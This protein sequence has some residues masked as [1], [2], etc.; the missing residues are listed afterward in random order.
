MTIRRKAL[1]SITIAVVLLTA[2]TTLVSAQA[3]ARAYS[4]GAVLPPL[5]EW[6]IIGPVLRFLG[7]VQDA[8]P[9]VGP[10]PDP[11]LPEYRI[12]S[13]EDVEQLHDIE[14][15]RRVRIIATDTDLN[16]MIRDLLSEAGHSEAA[17]LRVAFDDPMIAADA[18]VSTT[19]IDRAGVDVPA[20]VRGNFNIL[21]TFTAVASNCS[22]TVTF[23]EVKV[24]NWSFGLRPVANRLIN[25]QILKFWPDEVCAESVIVMD[26]EAAAEGYRRE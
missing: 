6:P 21:A 9:E 12:T 19:I 8:A 7:L 18:H 11:S 4:L 14:T 22:V 16:Q 1:I 15:N 20:W 2:S 10:T 5:P 3:S 25:Q 17:S 23:E 26:G 24:N 13:L